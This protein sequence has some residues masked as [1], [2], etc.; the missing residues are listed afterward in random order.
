MSRI[1]SQY[2]A[3]I[4]SN[5]RDLCRGGLAASNFQLRYYLLTSPSSACT[6]RASSPGSS[7]GVSAMKAACFK[8]RS[9]KR[10]RNTSKSQFPTADMFMTIQPRTRPCLR[11]VA[12]PDRDI[13]EAHRLLE[14]SQREPA[15]LLAD[16]VISGNVR[17]TRINAC[18]HRHVSTK[19]FQQL[20]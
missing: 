17:V 3:R 13:L 18:A 6:F 10:A 2:V 19:Q 16:D 14:M 8:R 4:Y 15:P 20:R 7:I 11:V 1:R 12:M 5:S 9:F